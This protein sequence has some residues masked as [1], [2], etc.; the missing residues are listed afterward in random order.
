MVEE[1]RFCLPNYEVSNLGNVRRSTAGRKTYA[2]RIMK[3]LMMKIG[4]YSVSPTVDGVNVPSYVHHLVA[5]AFIGPRPAGAE[6]NHKDGNKTNNDAGNLEYVTHAQNMA[7]ASIAGLLV[8]G[9]RHGS[10]K[11]KNQDIAAIKES[12]MAGMS[13]SAV[14]KKHGISISHSWQIVNGNSWRHVA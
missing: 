3:R 1:W 12:R 10:S 11:L 4:Y 8:R 13:Y 9:E 14:A 7:H 2:G 6:V 5:I